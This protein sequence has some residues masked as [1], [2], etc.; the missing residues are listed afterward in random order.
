M[1]LY[2][3]L[4]N[5]LIFRDFSRNF[6]IWTYFELKRIKNWTKKCANMVV[7]AAEL[8]MCRHMADCVH[9]TWH[10]CARVYTRVI[11]GLSIH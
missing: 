1:E 10:T 9:A 3:K 11:S 4:M 7:D 5:F 8:F 6:L 2:L